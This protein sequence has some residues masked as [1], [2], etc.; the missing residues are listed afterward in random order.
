MPREP[1]PPHRVSDEMRTCESVRP[2]CDEARFLSCASR[3]GA[4]RRLYR[5][6]FQRT[7]PYF[8]RNLLNV[9]RDWNKARPPAIPQ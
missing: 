5:K 8:S 4:G 1:A 3:G 7:T 6:I 9:E 2:H